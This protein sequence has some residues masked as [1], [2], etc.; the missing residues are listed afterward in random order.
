[1]IG[2]AKIFD[3]P[4]SLSRREGNATVKEVNIL[5]ETFLLDVMV[6]NFRHKKIAVTNT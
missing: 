2:E 3:Y 1:L 4:H 6:N 5:L